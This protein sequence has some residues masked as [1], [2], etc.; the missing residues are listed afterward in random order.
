[1]AAEAVIPDRIGQ[2]EIR[3]ELGSGAF[4]R[5]FA[6]IDTELGRPVAI[7]VLR[8]EFGSNPAFVERFRAEGASLARLNHPN[9]T[10]LYGLQRAGQ[11]LFLIMELIKG[12]TLDGL[13]AERRR[14]ALHE[15]RPIVAQVACGLHYA[16]Q[17]NVIHRDIKPSN[18]M[19]TPTGVVKIMD[20][21]IARSRGTRRMT[22]EGALGTYAY[23]APEQFRG[24]EGD[25]RS[26]LYSL[27]CVVYETLCGTVPFDAA[28]EAEIM[29][30][31]LEGTPTS[32]LNFVPDLDPAAAATVLRALAKRPEDRFQDTLVFARELGCEVLTGNQGAIVLPPTLLSETRMVDTPP[33]R[34]AR[35]KAGFRSGKFAVMAGAALLAVAA[36]G[37]WLLQ[38]AQHMSAFVTATKVPVPKPDPG[39]AS[40][41]EATGETPADL[42][43]RAN[44]LFAEHRSGEAEE[45]LVR[46]AR[47]NYVPALVALARIYS[48]LRSNRPPGIEMNVSR[49]AR[50]YRDAVEARDTSMDP[51]VSAE[52]AQLRRWLQ[53]RNS[54]GDS[55]ARLAL[56]RYYQ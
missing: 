53:E 23:M 40:V 19:L 17:N 6:G 18:L 47:R 11:E 12:R 2:F 1:M 22:R 38:P 3:D 46:A 48:P 20:F 7:K 16:H 45:L 5:V 42:V 27:A 29:H 36:G 33:A 4:G 37:Y 10:T 24:A 9:I 43:A 39:M 28:S 55:E 21:G 35:R 14:L 15:V 8:V 54:S 41:P 32:P 51:A 25:E 56:E 34:S 52:R 31:H 26:D 13:L 30:G 44:A 50:Y 49:S